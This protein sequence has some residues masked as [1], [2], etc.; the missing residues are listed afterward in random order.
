MHADPWLNRIDDKKADDQSD[1]RHHLEIKQSQSA[2]L[3]DLLH[4]FHT[5]NAGHDGTENNRR[6]DHLDQTDK[7]V[8]ERFHLSAD[9]G[10]EKA[11][12]N[13]ADDGTD[14]LKIKHLVYRRLLIDGFGSHN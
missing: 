10:R 14:H 2:G 9:V 11:Q 8:S 12:Q 5:G 3:A 4:V 1:R 7:S 13:T 6:D